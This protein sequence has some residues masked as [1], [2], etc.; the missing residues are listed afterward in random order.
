MSRSSLLYKGFISYS[1]AADGRLAPAVQ[2][3][4]HRFAKPWYRIRSMRLFRDQTNL[5]ASPGLWRSIES[6]LVASEYFLFMASPTAAQSHW[7]QKEVDWWI[8]NRGTKTFLILLTD[9]QIVW[10][11]TARDFD[12]AR[13]TALPPQLVKSFPEEPLY[14]DLRWARTVNQLSPRHSQFRSV[15]LDVAATL[16]GRSKDELD[17]DDVRQ[18]RIVR[19]LTMLMIAVL[20]ALVLAAGSAAYVAKQQRDL[21]RERFANLCK[22]LSESQ[23][24][25]D[26]ANHGSVYHFRSEYAA[27]KDD[28]TAL[29]Y[30]PWL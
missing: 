9:G 12:W 19:Q 27:I 26:A 4:L 28:C 22:A 30:E 2:H 11:E 5:A 1:H 23:V 14:S 13:T 29:G 20:S 16:L 8:Q 7:V 18:H 10:S 17:G 6:A 15:I 24:L 21:A 3:A 25:A